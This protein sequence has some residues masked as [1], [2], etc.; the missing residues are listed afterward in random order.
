MVA[1]LRYNARCMSAL[2]STTIMQKYEIFT[3]LCASWSIYL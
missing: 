2:T 1:S 3:P